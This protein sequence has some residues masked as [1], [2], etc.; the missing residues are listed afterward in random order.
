[1]HLWLERQGIHHNPK[2][3]LRVMN[4]VFYLKFGESGSGRTWGSKYINI[5]IYSTGSF[6]Q[7]GPTANG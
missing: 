4:T 2:T 7:T 1:M 5:K 6:T 3:V